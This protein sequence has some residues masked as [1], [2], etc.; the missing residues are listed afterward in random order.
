V[1][2]QPVRRLRT[3]ARL[4]SKPLSPWEREQQ[5]YAAGRSAAL[6]GLARRIPYDRGDDYAEGWASGYSRVA[7]NSMCAR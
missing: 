1:N 2:A 4:T 7:D 3:A 6:G 5:G